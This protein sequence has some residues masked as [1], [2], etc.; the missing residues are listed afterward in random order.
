MG[1]GQESETYIQDGVFYKEYNDNIEFRKV[2]REA[3]WLFLLK[4]SG[5][6]PIVYEKKFM[7][8]TLFDKPYIIQMENLD[9]YE[10]LKEWKSHKSDFNNRQQS[11]LL[12]QLIKGRY[13]IGPEM[14]YQDLHY[15][16]VMVKVNGNN[17]NVRFIDPGNIVYH[18]GGEMWIDWIKDIIYELKLSRIASGLVKGGLTK[19]TIPKE[20][21]LKIVGNT[22][23]ALSDYDT[24]ILEFIQNSSSDM[25][26]ERVCKYLKK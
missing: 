11:E 7:N 6:V 1:R 3:T 26:K 18:S 14:F 2:F 15:G 4:E 25:L 20:S 12:R 17:V 16:N 8:E 24:E 9:G 10:T 5:Y 23:I 13:A 21:F 22:K 19:E